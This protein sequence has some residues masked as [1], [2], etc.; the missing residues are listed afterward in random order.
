VSQAD[1]NI[2]QRKEGEKVEKVGIISIIQEK[3]Q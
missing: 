3:W 1:S 2:E